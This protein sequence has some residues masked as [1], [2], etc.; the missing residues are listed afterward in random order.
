[1]GRLLK[2]RMGVLIDDMDAINTS[3]TNIQADLKALVVTCLTKRILLIVTCTG[4]TQRATKQLDRIMPKAAVA[5]VP[6]PTVT[7]SITVAK[8][9]LKFFNAD[10]KQILNICQ[11][12][13]GD[14]GHMIETLQ[15]CAQTTDNVSGFKDIGIDA[16]DFI[17]GQYKG[18]DVNEPIS[19]PGVRDSQHSCTVPGKYL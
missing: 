13:K 7:Q 4:D 17:T 3:N 16:V 10:S 19:S 6:R 2:S 12:C 18:S 9:V 15:S 8:D 5:D 1:M 14:L 11:G